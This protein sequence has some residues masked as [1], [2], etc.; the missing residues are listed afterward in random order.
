MEYLNIIVFTVFI[1]YFRS[2]IDLIFTYIR[3][4]IR[5]FETVFWICAHIWGRLNSRTAIP[6]GLHHVS[7]SKLS[8]FLRS[9]C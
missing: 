8:E 7:M 1:Q 6:F 4:E 3:S 9:S 2:K 5:L